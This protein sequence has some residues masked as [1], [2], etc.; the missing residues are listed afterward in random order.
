MTRTQMSNDLS[1]RIILSIPYDPILAPT[2]KTI[3]GRTWYPSEKYW[4]F[5]NLSGILRKNL[6]LFAAELHYKYD[7]W[8]L[9]PGKY[10]E[11]CQT[12]KIKAGGGT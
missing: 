3:D 2:V 11:H 9:L 5:N 7:N 8:N 6:K 4:G 10:K 12:K 1:G